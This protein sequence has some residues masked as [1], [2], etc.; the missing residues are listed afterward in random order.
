MVRRDLQVAGIHPVLVIGAA[1]IGCGPDPVAVVA[2][3]VVLELLL[4]LTRFFVGKDV[5][6]PDITGALQRCTGG[7]VPDSLQVWFAPRRVLRLGWSGR[8]RRSYLLERSS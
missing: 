3:Q 1:H 4:E 2:S 6:G 5:F 8:F 7:V